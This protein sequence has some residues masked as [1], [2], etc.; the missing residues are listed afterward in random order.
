VAIRVD[1]RVAPELDPAALDQIFTFWSPL[2]PRT[3][4]RA[5]EHQVPAAEVAQVMGL[6]ETQVQHAF[7]DFTRK[8]RTTQYLRM[9]PLE[10]GDPGPPAPAL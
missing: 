2:S 3:V 9:V 7:D 6:T 4:F 5:Q 8:Q 10:L 1:R